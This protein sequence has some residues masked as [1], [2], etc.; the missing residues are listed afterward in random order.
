MLLVSAL[1]HPFQNQAPMAQALL[2]PLQRIRHLSHP[3]LSSDSRDC[4]FFEML[5]F[6]L[7]YP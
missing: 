5:K 7:N 3:V 1:N 2:P 6:L 4:M